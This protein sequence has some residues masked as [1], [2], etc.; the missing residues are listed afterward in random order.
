MLTPIGCSVETY[1][2]HAFADTN[3]L[4]YS[5]MEVLVIRCSLS[6]TSSLP[7]MHEGEPYEFN[8]MSEM[9][10]KGLPHLN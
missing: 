5:E 3:M 10:A 9:V 4:A 7:L 8:L 1:G 2:E 6:T